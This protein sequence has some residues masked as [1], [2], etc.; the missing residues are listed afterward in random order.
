MLPLTVGKRAD[1]PANAAPVPEGDPAMRNAGLC[2]TLVVGLLA[3][4]TKDQ[5]WFKPDQLL[6]PD[7]DSSKEKPAIETIGTLTSVVGTADVNVYGI[8]IVQGLP[9]TGH[10]PQPGELRRAALRILKQHGIEEAEKFLASG[11]SA[12]VIVSARIKAGARKGELL[13]V[14]LELE[15]KDNT[16]SLRGGQLLECELRQYTDLADISREGAKGALPGKVLARADGPILV[17]IAKGTDKSDERRGRVWG[18]GRVVEECN[19]ALVLNRESQDARL[20]KL[21]ADRVNERFYANIRGTARGMA[22]AK[23]NTS[24]TLRV[25][26]IY[27]HN[28]QRYIRIVRQIPLRETPGGRAQ[29]ERFLGEQLVDPATTVAAALK[30]EALGAESARTE[31]K[32]ALASP[33]PIVRFCA[34]EALAYLGDSA[35]GRPLAELV[36]SEPTLRAYALTALASLDEAV[37]ELELRELMREPSAETRYGAF[38]ALMT[39]NSHDP[40]VQG[41]RINESFYLHKVAPDSPGLVHATTSRRPELVIFG[42][43]AVLLPPFTLTAGANF[44]VAARQDDNRCLL[45]H[46]TARADREQQFCSYKLDDV[47]RQLGALGASYSDVVDL[48]QQAAHGHNLSCPFALDALPRA[49]TVE[50]I[51]AAGAIAKPDESIS[52]DLGPTPSLFAVPGR[53]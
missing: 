6:S 39:L 49:P 20:A 23:N 24:I 25:P 37:C 35:A 21:I 3:G 27:R 31:L 15:A 12:V 33:L 9:G 45:S 48:L 1:L 4:C 19:F 46:I 16:S 29:Y 30:L 32:K 14:G 22:H 53:K 40:A 28:W 42:E 2:A 10:E 17:D 43:E 26:D 36:R 5:L 11:S 8:G 50:E 7:N 34:A 47:V 51:A 41:A 44:V 13:D 18:G 38:R 52:V